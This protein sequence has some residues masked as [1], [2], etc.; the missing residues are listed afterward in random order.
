MKLIYRLIT[1]FVLLEVVWVLFD[2]EGIKL[3]ATAAFTI[4]PLLLRSLMIK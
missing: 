1:I 4:I 2:E 3:K